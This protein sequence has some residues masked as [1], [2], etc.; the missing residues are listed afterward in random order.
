MHIDIYSDVVCPWCYIGKKRLDEVLTGPVG[1]GVSVA[2]V[3]GDAQL[4]DRAAQDV[5]GRVDV[6][7]GRGPG[8]DGR[9]RHDGSLPR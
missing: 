5:E 9:H 2:S 3:V 6:G 7:V 1:E 4:G 8:G